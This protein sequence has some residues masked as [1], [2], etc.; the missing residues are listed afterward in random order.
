[1][2]NLIV[3]AT[4]DDDPK[5][6]APRYTFSQCKG[7]DDTLFGAVHG[8]MDGQRNLCQE[9]ELWELKGNW[10]CIDNDFDGKMTCKKCIKEWEKYPW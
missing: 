4:C 8:S 9:K 5:P 7:K 2:K 10:W 6:E 1:M 3:N